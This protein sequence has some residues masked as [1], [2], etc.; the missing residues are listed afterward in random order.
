MPLAETLEQG[1]IRDEDLLSFGNGF[2]RDNVGIIV[3]R[4]EF[5][6]GHTGVVDQGDF[7][8][9]A[10]APFTSKDVRYSEC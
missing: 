7:E 6:V 3:F 9:Q 4:A 1:I 2:H 10:G 5:C 8:I